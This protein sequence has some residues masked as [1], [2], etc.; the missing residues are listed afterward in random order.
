MGDPR[1]TVLCPQRT[2]DPIPSM[3]DIAS[4]LFR[5]LQYRLICNGWL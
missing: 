5:R 2:H 3:A 1:L 4:S